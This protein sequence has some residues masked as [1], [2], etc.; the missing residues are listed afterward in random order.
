MSDAGLTSDAEPWQRP[1]KRL[2]IALISDFSYPR[3][4]GVE[5]HQYY[6]A[7]GLIRRK[8]KVILISGT[9]D[10][11]RQ[12]V[13]YLSQGL[14]VYYCPLRVIV[15]Q[16]TPPTLFAFLPLLRNILIREKIDIVHGH[17]STS[18][19][20]AEGILFAK[21]MGYKAVYT[22]HSLF[23]FADIGAVHINKMIKFWLSEID[24][25]ICVS[26]TSRENLVLR[27]YL[28]PREISVIPNAVDATKFTPD[29]KGAP[30]TKD[31]VIIVIL[32]RLVY[33]KGI[34]LVIDVIPAICARFPSVNF[35]IGGD[36]PKRINLEEMREK[37]QLHD[38]IEMLGAIQHC[39]VR[40]VLV[41]GHI[42]LNCSLTEAFCIAILE[43]VSCG[44]YTVST[45]VGGIS[46]V[47]PESMITLTEPNARDIIEALSLAI[48]RVR[49]VRPQALHEQVKRMYNWNSVAERTERVYYQVMKNRPEPLSV[50]LRRYYDCGPVS[51]FVFCAVIAL[52]YLW[53]AL[54]EWIFPKDDID[55]A[56]D[57]PDDMFADLDDNDFTEGRSNVSD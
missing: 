2:S 41:K 51:G 35:V 14:K 18:F 53:V 5:M 31:R 56:I 28:D 46:E 17:Q 43:A 11:E 57:V 6:L 12:G 29:P 47:L 15:Q 19:M 48:S 13:R 50:R 34:D 33:R 22:D 9:Y 26:H 36:G 52:C 25:V 23:G 30:P 20:S 1:G 16:A 37:Y 55:D 27:A 3:M 39:N 4:G 24:H 40:D 44:L 38:R 45:R 54:I 7:Q 32:S 21:T 49:R 10:N 42:F 8:H